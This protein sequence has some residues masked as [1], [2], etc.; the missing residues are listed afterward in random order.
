MCARDMGGN[1]EI[2]QQL[3]HPDQNLSNCTHCHVV[4]V[5]IGGV[6]IG[7]RIY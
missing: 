5:T 1:G 2:W 7:N 6:R 4:S 3:L